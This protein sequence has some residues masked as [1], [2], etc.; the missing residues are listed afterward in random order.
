M[1]IFWW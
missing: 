1:M